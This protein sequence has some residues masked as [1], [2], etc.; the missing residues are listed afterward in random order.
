MYSFNLQNI[1]WVS[2]FLLLFVFII[3]PKKHHMN[4]FHYHEK[5]KK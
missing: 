1:N 2:L 4:V 3:L 5:K